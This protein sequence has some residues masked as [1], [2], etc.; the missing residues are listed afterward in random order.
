M[1]LIASEIVL[2]WGLPPQVADATGLART[3]K[4]FCISE[5]PEIVSAVGQLLAS[6]RGNPLT[7]LKKPARFPGRSGGRRPTKSEEV[8]G[9][10]PRSCLRVKTMG[11]RE[12]AIVLV[13]MLAGLMRGTTGFGG[14][15][16]M[17]PS[18]SF[19]TGP[20]SAVTT[21]L[22]LETVAALTMFP[23]AWPKSNKKM[24]LSLLAPA[25]VTVPVGS[26]LLITIDP[27]IARKLIS[28]VVVIFSLLLLA[29]PRCS[30]S[31]PMA[32]SL[33][34]GGIAGLFLGAT[35]IGAPPVILFLL[36]GPDPQAITRANLAVF[37]T[38]MSA[39]GLVMLVVA[40]AAPSRQWLP[41]SLLCIPY[42]G[43]TWLGSAV[44]PRLSD[45]ALRRLALGFMLSI[46]VIGLLL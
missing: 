42:L 26:Y 11:M 14:A 16:L 39:I 10:R 18:L 35:G 21:A 23:D 2:A 4:H 13:I 22:T 5:G 40:G 41:V 20:V 38:A 24:L 33:T 6:R 17:A 19:L 32:T 7:C 27:F 34:L 44:F 43:A 30:N 8:H 3:Q 25:C 46:G 9:P 12:A 1:L 15:M 28:C 37:V 31:P 36:S 45:S 29:G